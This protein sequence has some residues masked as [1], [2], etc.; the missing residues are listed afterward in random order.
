M[1]FSS[2]LPTMTSCSAEHNIKMALAPPKE[3]S[4]MGLNL[5]RDI[6]ELV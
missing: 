2:L 3:L 6:L 5:H 4:H 1:V